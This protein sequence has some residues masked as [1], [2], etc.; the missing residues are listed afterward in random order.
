MLVKQE[1]A[2]LEDTKV[3][4]NKILELPPRKRQRRIPPSVSVKSIISQ[5]DG[6]AQNPIDLT[7]SKKPDHDPAEALKHI[8]VKFIK[9]YQDVRPPYKGTYTKITSPTQVRKF[10]RNPFIRYRPD[11]DYDY[12]SEAEWEDPGEGE[13]LLSEDEEEP[14]EDDDDDINEFL[15]NEDIEEKRRPHLGNM[16]T[17]CTG[18]CWA[19]DDGGPD[20]S[21]FRIDMLKG[22]HTILISSQTTCSQT[23]LEVPTFPINPYSTTYW[24][25]PMPPPSIP[26]VPTIDPTTFPPTVISKVLPTDAQDTITS[27]KQAKKLIPLDLLLEFKAAVEGSDATKVVLVDI[28]KRKFPKHSKDVLKDSLDAVAERKGVLLKDRKWVLK[29]GI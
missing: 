13:D 29:E 10:A 3:N 8:P 12:D 23:H 24:P 20:L 21:Q 16:E 2:L 17:S 4:F 11:T 26:A 27:A 7:S 5:I 25:K 22:T 19:E 28:L 15:D 14:E 18:I 1:K 9:F 6:A